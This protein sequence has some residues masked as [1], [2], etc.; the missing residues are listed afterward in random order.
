MQ[1]NG[2]AMYTRARRW[3][4]R[5]QPGSAV[6]SAAQLLLHTVSPLARLTYSD[7]K[8]NRTAKHM[9]AHDAIPPTLPAMGSACRTVGHQTVGC[10]ARSIMSS[11]MVC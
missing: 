1:C 10:N 2:T 6:P 9:A 4:P 3:G 8:R 11:T 7:D 5:R